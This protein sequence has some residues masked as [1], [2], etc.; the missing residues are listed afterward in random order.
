MSELEPT[1]LPSFTTALSDDIE[2]AVH[3]VA[4]NDTPSNRRQ[5]IRC[6]FA[7]IEGTFWL[8][9]L[10]VLKSLDRFKILSNSERAIFEQKSYA[11]S[12]KGV[13]QERQNF[14]PLRTGIRF[15]GKQL[16]KIDTDFEIDFTSE[17]WQNLD[18]LKAVRDR[19]VHPKKVDDLNVD[20]DDVE[21][22]PV[23]YWWMVEVYGNVLMSIAQSTI[24]TTAPVKRPVLV[25]QNALLEADYWR[26]KVGKFAEMIDTQQFDFAN[27]IRSPTMET[28]AKVLEGP[29]IGKAGKG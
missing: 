20:L 26:T 14:I 27:A 29:T 5:V 28:L 2:A 11:V 21:A 8:M 9:N 12:D 6:A 7:G 3:A 25:F 16:K 15:I 10:A 13:V 19:L 18:R 4:N 23:A 22:A 1:E 24:G 17:G